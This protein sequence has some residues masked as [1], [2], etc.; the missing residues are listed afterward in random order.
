MKTTL[1]PRLAILL[2]GLSLL[3]AGCQTRGMLAESCPPPGQL[4]PV[5]AGAATAVYFD[6]SGNPLGTM[7]GSMR[8]VAEDMRGTSDNQMCATPL[9]TGPGTCPIG[10]CPMVILGTAYCFRCS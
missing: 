4:V 7:P 3:T 9:E 6:M 1:V 5:P 10:W 8:G 2:A